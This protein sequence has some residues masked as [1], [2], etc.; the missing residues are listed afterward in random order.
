MRFQGE[1]GGG[2][3]AQLELCRVGPQ[4][5]GTVFTERQWAG[6]GRSGGEI[7][8]L[9]ASNDWPTEQACGSGNSERRGKVTVHSCPVC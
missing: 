8:P 3:G 4:C 6:N 7:L 9:H 1:A 5:F 2:V